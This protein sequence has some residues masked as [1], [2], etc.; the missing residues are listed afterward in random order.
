VV[1]ERGPEAEEDLRRS[2][3]RELVHLRAMALFA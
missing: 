3:G 1:V 2:D